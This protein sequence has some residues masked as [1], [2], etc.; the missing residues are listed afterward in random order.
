MA[1][2]LAS[3]Q[4]VRPCP[5]N[6]ATDTYNFAPVNY[7][8]LPQTRYTFDASMNYNLT[9]NMT[10]YGK[11]SYVDHTTPQQLAPTPAQVL[12][13]DFAYADSPFLTDQAKQMFADSYDADGDGV[14]SLSRFRRRLVENEVRASEDD[15]TAA[16]LR[17]G[18][19]GTIQDNWDYDVYGAWGKVEYNQR[20]TGDAAESRLTMALNTV[21][22][23]TCVDPNDTSVTIPGCTAANI[24]GEGNISQDAVDYINVGATN[25]TEY[26]QKYYGATI[27]GTAYELPAGPLGIAFGAEYREEDSSFTPDEFLASGDVLG[28]NSGKP[29]EG[30]YDVTEF[31]TEVNIPLLADVTGAYSLALNGA[32]R[33]SDYSNVD[34]QDTYSA[35]VEWR[36]IEELLVRA[37]YQRAVRAPSVYELF[38]GLSNNFPS[39]SDPCAGGVTGELRSFC[40]SEGVPAS[41][42]DTFEEADSQVEATNGGNPNL[43]VEESDTY[44]AGIVWQPSF[45][46]GLSLTVDWYK[47]EID[48]AI[49]EAGG[50]TNNQ[51]ALCYAG[52]NSASS[53]CQ[54]ITRNVD[55]DIINVLTLNDNIAEFTTEGIDFQINYGWEMDFGLG[56]SG[57]NFDLSFM[58]THLTESSFIPAPGQ[59]QRDCEG[60]FGFSLW[61]DHHRYGTAREQVEH[62]PHLHDWPL[63]HASGLDMDGRGRR[64]PHRRRYAEEPIAGSDAG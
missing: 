18:L 46:E 36:P 16:Q 57:S 10:A 56:G 61:P 33:Y 9:D 3:C 52:L 48:D 62:S 1:A 6:G 12:N 49:D 37:Q 51:I 13:V 25:T 53:E 20:L 28:F 26:E 29:T 50:G 64:H 42:I 22:G 43:D 59:P 34:E 39:Y 5:Y 19:K 4:T 55:G 11:G 54:A 30:D 21:D 31:F 63:D 15:R 38:L 47:I 60:R 40:I 17:V 27:A 24:W 32:Y 35:G 44:T 23:V 14:A 8:Q 58:G 45:V 2:A 41:I 7:L